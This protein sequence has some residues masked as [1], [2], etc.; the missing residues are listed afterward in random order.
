MTIVC[1]ILNK[2]T[3]LLLKQFKYTLY[4]LLFVCN[5]I[6]AQQKQIVIEF[7]EADCISKIDDLKKNF[8]ENKIIPNEYELPC[9]IALS[10]YPELSKTKIV[11]KQ[12]HIRTTMT[13]RP[14]FKVLFQSKKNRT[15]NICINN[16][17][18]LNGALLSDISFNEQIGVIG[19][20][21]AHITDYM[22]KSKLQLA[23]TFFKYIFNPN[24]KRRLEAQT[25]IATINH[26]LGWQLYD[27]GYFLINKSTVS[28]KYIKHKQKFYMSALQLFEII[29]NN[30]LYNSVISN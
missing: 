3:I 28:K 12:K 16:S 18:I 26:G 5:G 7:K 20:E 23:A 6:Y 9:L 11:F 17:S 13:S 30:P 19:H 24:F 21:L 29:L 10:Y 2:A 15:Y 25:D 8:E 4:L 27:F 22:K 14:P 1:N